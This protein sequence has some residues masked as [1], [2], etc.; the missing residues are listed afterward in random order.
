MM[1]FNAPCKDRQKTG[2]C[3]LICEDFYNFSK[4]RLPE[5]IVVIAESDAYHRSNL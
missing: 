3:V 4:I 2:Y 5:N 1:K